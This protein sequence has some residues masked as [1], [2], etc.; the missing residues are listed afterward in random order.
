MSAATL[1]GLCAA[2]LV[3]LGLVQPHARAALA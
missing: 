1:F 2:L 3:G